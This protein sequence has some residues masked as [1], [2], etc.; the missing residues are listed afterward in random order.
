MNIE[1]FNEYVFNIIS[2]P[3]IWIYRQLEVVF[4]LYIYPLWTGKPVAE[5][6]NPKFVRENLHGTWNPSI[7]IDIPYEKCINMSNEALLKYGLEKTQNGHLRRFLHPQ[8]YYANPKE[9]TKWGELAWKNHLIDLEFNKKDL[10]EKLTLDPFNSVLYN[11]NIRLFNQDILSYNIQMKISFLGYND[12]D[13]I[14][15]FFSIIFFFILY[16]CYLV[17]YHMYKMHLK[18]ERA[19]YI[20]NE[21]GLSL[22]VSDEERSAMDMHNAWNESSFISKRFDLGIEINYCLTEGTL[23]GFELFIIMFF[24]HCCKVAYLFLYTYVYLFYIVNMEF[25]TYIF[26]YLFAFLSIFYWRK[27]KYEI[28][29]ATHRWVEIDHYYSHFLNHYFRTLCWLNLFKLVDDAPIFWYVVVYTFVMIWTY[30]S[31]DSCDYF[32]GWNQ[33]YRIDIYN[34][35]SVKKMHFWWPR[36]LMNQTWHHFYITLLKPWHL[37]IIYLI[38]FFFLPVIALFLFIV[39]T[40]NKIHVYINNK[41]FF[42]NSKRYT[43]DEIEKQWQKDRVYN[44]IEMEKEK[45]K[46]SGFTFH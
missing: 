40:Q 33:E 20:L 25:F 9:S 36:I 1:A 14:E 46:P 29:K 27:W 4:Y 34:R 11:N 3:F 42:W 19:E 22:F 35:N 12:I 31:C 24:L 18:L 39:R 44:Y 45:N 5:G 37:R 30:F 16:I 43:F 10:I 28:K 26:V 41:F 2:Y 6:W 17:F 23:I 8:M 7:S 32:M 21:N 13:L 15:I 38:L